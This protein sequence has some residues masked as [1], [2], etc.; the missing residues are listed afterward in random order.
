MAV[1]SNPKEMG[2]M[3]DV[4]NVFEQSTTGCLGTVLDSPKLKLWDYFL[5]IWD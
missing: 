4:G 5:T 1:L 3:L 2:R